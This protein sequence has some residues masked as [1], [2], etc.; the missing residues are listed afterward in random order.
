[1]RVILRADLR[2]LAIVTWAVP[3]TSLAKLLPHGLLPQTVDDKGEIGLISIV[4]MFDRTL[5]QTYAQL[6]ERTYVT[7]RDGTGAGAYFFQSLANTWQATAFRLLMGVPLFRAD[8][9]LAVNG[10]DYRF[11]L[12]RSEVARLQ[13][14]APPTPITSNVGLDPYRV[15]SVAANPMTGYTQNRG[16][17]YET[18]VDH[19]EIDQ[20][21][22]PDIT[23]S[24]VTTSWM[25]TFPIVTT[26][27]PIAAWHVPFTPFNIIFPSTRVGQGVR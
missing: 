6:N 3:R 8:T 27:A 12:G 26:S 14:N 5:W 19:T 10:G 4:T 23:V 22:A 11:D 13:L 9:R 1:M 18:K 20:R 24:K 25:Q 16:V 15:R 2:Q 17:L 21:Q 7:R